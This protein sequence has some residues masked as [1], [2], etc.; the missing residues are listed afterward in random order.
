MQQ[1]T[2]GSQRASDRTLQR[3]NIKNYEAPR[4]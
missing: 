2:L 3:H 1:K 4:W